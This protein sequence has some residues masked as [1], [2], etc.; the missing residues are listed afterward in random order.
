MIRPSPLFIDLGVAVTLGLSILYVWGPTLGIRFYQDDYWH[1]F[2][3][4]NPYLGLVPGAI[5][6]EP[7]WRPLGQFVPFYV[8]RRLFGLDPFIL[9]LANLSI[10]LVNGVL[11]YRLGL[12]MMMRMRTYA[13]V[14]AIFYSLHL[15]HTRSFQGAFIENLLSATL[16]LLALCFY[17]RFRQDRQRWA[18]WVSVATFT[19]ALL[20]K[21]WSVTF[22]LILF[23]Y[24]VAC[25][26]SSGSIRSWRHWKSIGIRL[27]GYCLPLSAYLGIRM[28]LYSFS[29]LEGQYGLIFGETLPLRNLAQYLIWTVFPAAASGISLDPMVAGLLAASLFWIIL[30]SWGL[31][32]ELVTLGLGWFVITL[33]PVLFISRIE[34]YVLVIPLVGFAIAVG[35]ICKLAV[36]ILPRDSIRRW[37]AVLFAIVLFGAMLIPA[38][39]EVRIQQEETSWLVN[40]QRF[41]DCTLAYVSHRWPSPPAHSIFFFLDLHTQDVY[42]LGLG[43][44]INVYYNDNTLRTSF[45]PQPRGTYSPF[46]NIIA[47]P[48]PL[49]DKIVSREMLA[50]FCDTTPT[51]RIR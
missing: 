5:P 48:S 8:S 30:V 25:N 2:L 35:A 42:S 27:A 6:W 4:Q 17:L 44:A 23:W 45:I 36:Q 32:W 21:E 51:L 29:S 19:A 43:S 1:L 34:S 31:R 3:T 41:V 40:A 38:A 50:A 14:A 18:Y 13:L 47:T 46:V 11:V 28:S 20:T 26:S 9:H 12:M 15:A 16:Y 33:G 22:V 24:E 10:H 39:R 49:E 7:H 37:T